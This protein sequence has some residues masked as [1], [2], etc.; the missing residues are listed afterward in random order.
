MILQQR[1][2]R[3][4]AAGGLG[5]AFP[6]S[7]HN[8]GVLEGDIQALFQSVAQPEIGLRQTGAEPPDG[9]PFSQQKLLMN[10]VATRKDSGVWPER[11]R[12]VATVIHV[13]VSGRGRVAGAASASRAETTRRAGRAAPTF[14]P[15]LRLRVSPAS[16]ILGAFRCRRRL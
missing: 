9:E 5:G 2:V 6:H 13:R 15:W 14:V 16:I 11:Q 8:R 1:R 10:P 7:D 3:V 12:Q 4:Q